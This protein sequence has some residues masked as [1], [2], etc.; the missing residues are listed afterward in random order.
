MHYGYALVWKDKDGYEHPFEHD[1]TTTIFNHKNAAEKV[2]S[3]EKEFIDNRLKHGRAVTTVH[4]RWWWFD[5]YVTEFVR[6]SEEERVRFKRIFD[7]LFVKR[8][9]V[10]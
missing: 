8:V 6:Y 5:K 9:T 10:A 2:L 1:E 4:P 7:T 3:L